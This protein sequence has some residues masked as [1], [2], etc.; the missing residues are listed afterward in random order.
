MELKLREEYGVN[1]AMI[2][3]GAFTIQAPDRQE[4]IYPD[5]TLYVIGTDDQVVAFKKY[6]DFCSPVRS[7]N[8]LP[9]DELTLQRIEVKPESVL[10]GKTIKE[11]SIRERTKGLVVGIER[12]GERILNPESTALIQ[13]GDLLWIVGN[14]RRIMVL[15]KMIV[16]NTA[17]Y[18]N[19]LQLVSQQ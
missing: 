18:D 4:R 7:R 13:E 2:K 9:E 12:N 5:D 10:V 1:V 6:L 16:K 8:I 19:N 15:E 3:R 11:S 14:T 17:V